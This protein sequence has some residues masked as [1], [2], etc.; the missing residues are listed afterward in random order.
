MDR[1]ATKEVDEK[2]RLWNSVNLESAA[3]NKNAVIVSLRSLEQ[4]DATPPG[5]AVADLPI[6]ITKIGEGLR[7]WKTRM[8]KGAEKCLRG[9]RVLEMT[10]VIAAPVAGRTLAAHGA[11]MLWVRNP[12][13][14]SLPALNVNTGREKRTC[15][16]D[17]NDE[18]DKKRFEKL[19]GEAGVFVQRVVAGESLEGKGFGAEEI[20]RKSREGILFGT[21]S[22]YGSEGPWK[23]NRGIDSMVQTC[24]GI[25]VAEAERFAAGEASRVLPHQA[26]DHA[27]EYFLAAGIMAVLYKQAMEGGSHQVEVSLAAMMKYLRSLGQFEGKSGFECE[28]YKT[29]KD[30]P[31]ESSKTRQSEFGNLRAVRHTASIEGIDVGWENWRDPQDLMTLCGYSKRV[32][33]RFSTSLLRM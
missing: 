24:L 6:I 1:A 19:L 7:E 9:V 12:K 33:D 13:L 30:V 29:Q 5:R 32:L 11:D 18:S 28:E 22:A 14:P 25:N 17:L 16:L 8:G 26:L 10:S 31:E 15:Q 23:D 4:W 21:L 3:F 20:G 2:T 27:S